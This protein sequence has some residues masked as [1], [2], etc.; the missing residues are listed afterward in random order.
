MRTAKGY[1]AILR[2]CFLPALG[3]RKAEVVTTAEMAKLHLSLKDRPYQANRLLA[4]I[5]SMYT[6]AARRGLVVRGTNPTIGLERFK[7]A[8][9]ERFLGTEELK[10][11]GEA[12]RL[13][14]SDGLPWR[15]DADASSNKHLAKEPNQRTVFTPEVTLAFRLLLFTG[16]RLREILDLEWAHVDLERGLLMLPDSKDWPEDGRAQ[17]SCAHDLAAC[18]SKQRFRYTGRNPGS[19]QVRPQEAV[20]RHSAA[21]RPRGGAYSRSASH[22]CVHRR[23]IEPWS[24]DR[25]KATR[26]LSARHDGSIRTSRRRSTPPSC[27]IIGGKIAGAMEA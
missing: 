24:S 9:R 3:K 18:R 13:A 5:G 23:R 25:W 27:N 14:E 20:A 8:K 4:I 19:A 21:R 10:R 12:L 7:E 22:V 15:L 16:A 6:F 26:P 2:R 1:D 11:L 17:C